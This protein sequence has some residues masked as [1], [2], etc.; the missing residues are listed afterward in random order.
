MPTSDVNSHSNSDIPPG[1]EEK[2]IGGD[3]GILESGDLRAADGSS[4]KGGEDV[5]GLQDLD[6]VLNM[7]MHLVNNVS[8]TSLP[9]H[10][11]S[12]TTGYFLSLLV[13]IV[14]T[15]CEIVPFLHKRPLMRLAGRR[16]I[17]SS[18]SSMASGKQNANSPGS[19]DPGAAS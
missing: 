10:T 8:A 14:V 18:S 3:N 19:R 5:L 17:L 1:L 6:P 12:A 11:R 16:T 7:K 15:D 2:K 13:W 9:R 4:L